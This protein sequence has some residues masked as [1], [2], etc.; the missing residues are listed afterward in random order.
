MLLLDASA[1]VLFANRTAAVFLREHR[2]VHL[3]NGVLEAVRHPETRALHDAIASC[4]RHDGSTATNIFLP[5][6]DGDGLIRLAGCVIPLPNDLRGTEARRPVALF[7]IVDPRCMAAPAPRQLQACFGLTAAEATVAREVLEGD[8][9]RACAH[10]LRISHTTARTHLAHV[11][12]KTGTKHQAE[13][14][15][16]LLGLHPGVHHS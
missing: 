12:E 9:L 2:G 6:T 10:R 16:V 5:I 8:G 15:R 7:T 1:H 11:F 4:S 13:L 14:V 3:C